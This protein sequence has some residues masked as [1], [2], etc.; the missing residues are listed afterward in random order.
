MNYEEFMR[1]DY[2]KIIYVLQVNL[3]GRMVNVVGLFY[4][5]FVIFF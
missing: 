3:M 5:Y 1:I 4:F 2:E